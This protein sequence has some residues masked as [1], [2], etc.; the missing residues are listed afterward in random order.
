MVLVASQLLYL[1]P[2]LSSICWCPMKLSQCTN[3][4]IITSLLSFSSF[5]SI[6]F[7][8]PSRDNLSTFSFYLFNT[9]VKWTWRVNKLVYFTF[10]VNHGS[11]LRP[12]YLFVFIGKWKIPKNFTVFWLKYFLRLMYIPFFCPLKSPLFTYFK[13]A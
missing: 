13:D 12:S 4:T 1:F 6:W 3:I 2:F 11:L 8:T 10:L 9:R 5:R 7:Q